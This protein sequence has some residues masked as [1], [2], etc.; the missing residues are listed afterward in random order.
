[1]RGL[2]QRRV[3]SPHINIIHMFVFFHCFH[4]LLLCTCVLS[5]LHSMVSHL[6]KRHMILLNDYL[7]ITAV[8]SSSTISIVRSKSSERYKINQALKL[9]K[10]AIQDTSKFDEESRN[11]FEVIAPHRTY[12]LVAETEGE[13]EKWV[14]ELTMAILAIHQFSPKAR[15]P[16]WQHEVVRGT[17]HS[18]ALY[19]DSNCLAMHLKQLNGSPPEPDSVGMFPIHWAALKGHA[20]IIST[21][22]DYGSPV[23]ELNN[24]LNTP[25]L[26]AAAQGHD[27]AVQL[28]LDR[29]V[30]V[31]VNV[32][33]CIC[34][35]QY[36]V[37]M[38]VTV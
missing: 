3:I 18:A 31:C 32:Q 10:I 15:V 26:I 22:I 23:D 33:V 27:T 36:S 5:G 35:S 24:G 4:N 28:L 30:Y 37:Y 7:L 9:D 29:C 14:N 20:N 34:V 19:G 11:T 38:Y 12:I 2:Y 17:L 8:V 13:K 6:S 25:L 1:M 21:L 16:G